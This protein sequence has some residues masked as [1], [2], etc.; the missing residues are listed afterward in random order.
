MRAFF[1]RFH[2]WLGL[3][4][5][6]ILTVIGLTGSLL[7]CG[8]DIYEATH[9]RLFA[10]APRGEKLPLNILVAKA[11]E[12]WPEWRLSVLSLESYGQPDSALLLRLQKGS[13]PKGERAYGTLNP[14]TG[15]PIVD[16][17]Q[18]R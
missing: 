17:D 4:C 13:G 5:A 7:V 6:L 2:G 11:R 16:R 1:F 3:G 8:D 9:P 10:V 15:I 18:A 12:T 14:Y